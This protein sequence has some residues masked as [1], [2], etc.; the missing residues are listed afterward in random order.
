MSES[1]LRRLFAAD[2]LSGIVES[3]AR[4]GAR[5][6]GRGAH[7]VGGDPWRPCSPSS[8]PSCCPTSSC[9]WLRRP[10]RRASPSPSRHRRA[11]VRVRRSP[12]AS[13]AGNPTTQPGR[14]QRVEPL[15]PR[16]AAARAHLRARARRRRP[17][18]GSRPSSATPAAATTL[19]WSNVADMQVASTFELGFQAIP[20]PAVYP[21][22]STVAEP[23]PGPHQHRPARH[24]GVRRRRGARARHRDRERRRRRRR[25]W[26]ARSRSPS[27]S[28][29][30]RASCCGGCTSTPPSTRCGCARPR[31]GAPTASSSPTTCRPSWSSSAAAARTTRPA[32]STPAP[33][34]SAT[35]RPAVPGCVEPD[36][37]ETV[38]RPVRHHLPARRLHPAAA[39]P[40]ATSPP[41]TRSCCRY[42]AGVP[43]R[44][45]V[46]LPGRA[47]SPT[48]TRA[49]RGPTSTT[50][51]GPP[52]ARARARSRRP[53]TRHVAGDYQGPVAP[54]AGTAVTGSTTATVSIEDLRMRKSVSPTQFQAGDIARYTLVLDTSEYTSAS[55]VLIT[56]VVP[57][58]LC[59]LG[60]PGTNFVGGTRRSATGRRP[61]PRRFPTTP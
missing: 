24:P 25:H 13:T 19:V 57:S 5:R 39:G 41:A 51:P 55:N 32:R 49:S 53:T 26:S 54:G 35:A 37:V 18:P 45:N 48:P 59:P 56:D 10:R 8:S 2:T 20:D 22:G 34:C 30:P 31:S 50:T 38:D 17:A 28:P 40:S 9:R 42:A 44:A 11:C 29:A 12:T 3:G 33:R 23:G 21:V 47:P 43:L 46:A 6:P 60:G 4:P 52:R 58:G 61:R 1:A 7:A 14:R 16:R 36:S 27:P 15:V